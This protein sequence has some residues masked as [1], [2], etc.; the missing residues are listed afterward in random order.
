MGIAF[1]G[2]PPAGHIIECV[3]SILQY[4][5]TYTV[6]VPR[7]RAMSFDIHEYGLSVPTV[8]DMFMIYAPPCATKITFKNPYGLFDEES[9]SENF[10][11]WFLTLDTF[12]YEGFYKSSP[13]IKYTVE[14]DDIKVSVECELEFEVDEGVLVWYHVPKSITSIYRSSEA[15]MHIDRGATQK[16]IR[17]VPSVPEDD[18][19][20]VDTLLYI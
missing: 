12:Q 17:I 2:A 15:S 10:P 4:A 16:D 18:I 6:R 11:I 1:T 7:D 3:K 20:A 9:R 14:E 19:M 13:G 5:D 8:Y